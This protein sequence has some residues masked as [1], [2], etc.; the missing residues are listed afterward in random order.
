MREVTKKVLP[1][2]G[3]QLDVDL[4]NFYLNLFPTF[5]AELMLKGPQVHLVSEDNTLPFCQYLPFTSDVGVRL[6]GT[7][8]IQSLVASWGNNLLSPYI[9]YL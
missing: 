9:G 6:T 5:S 8:L 4:S 3:K 7:N 2:W 1:S